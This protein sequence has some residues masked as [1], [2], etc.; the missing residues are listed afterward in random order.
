VRTGGAGIFQ[1]LYSLGYGMDDRGS[2]PLSLGFFSSPLRPDRLWGLPGSLS[3]VG[4]CAVSPGL[5]RLEC[6][7]DHSLPSIAKTKNSWSCTSTL[8][9]HFHDVAPN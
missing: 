5:K 4:T 6:E 2:I 8:P 1:S 7:A 9:L 3:P